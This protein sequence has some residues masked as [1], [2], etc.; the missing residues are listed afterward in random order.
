MVNCPFKLISSPGG[1]GDPAYI[2]CDREKCA[3]YVIRDDEARSCAV[4]V[5]T[6][7]LWYLSKLSWLVDLAKR[8]NR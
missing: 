3:W 5:I 4:R 2:E 8:G 1:N 7:H 6:Q